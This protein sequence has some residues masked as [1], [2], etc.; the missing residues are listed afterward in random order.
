MRSNSPYPSGKSVSHT[1]ML[2]SPP[3]VNCQD[4][5]RPF[6]QDTECAL[7]PLCVKLMSDV[8][9]QLVSELEI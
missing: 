3:L 1:P 5:E 7:I 6:R 2:S 9:G 4:P 8:F